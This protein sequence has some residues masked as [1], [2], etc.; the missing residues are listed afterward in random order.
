MIINAG[1]DGHRQE[2]GFICRTIYREATQA[3]KAR[4]FCV[5][6]RRV[7][8]VSARVPLKLAVGLLVPAQMRYKTLQ[9]HVY[10]NTSERARE[11]DPK[12]VTSN[13][14]SCDVASVRRSLSL[15]FT[16]IPICFPRNQT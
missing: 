15:N 6:I 1:F 11:S 9:Q 13:G 10:Q 2:V 7:Q 4:G 12:R 3:R 14:P 8:V 5:K 16:L